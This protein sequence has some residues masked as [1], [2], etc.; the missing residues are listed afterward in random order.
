MITLGPS[1]TS[2]NLTSTP[3]VLDFGPGGVLGWLAGLVDA[4]F[5][6]AVRPFDVEARA[7]RTA[8]GTVP[9]RSWNSV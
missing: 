6:D 7:L 3:I 1:R 2:N 4:Q 9:S 8:T 5:A